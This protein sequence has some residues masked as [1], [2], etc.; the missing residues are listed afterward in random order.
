MFI[1]SLY[2]IVCLNLVISRSSEYNLTGDIVLV[3]NGNCSFTI[4]AREAQ[5]AGAKALIVINHEEDE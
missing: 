1:N 3:T 2:E 5:G 4:K